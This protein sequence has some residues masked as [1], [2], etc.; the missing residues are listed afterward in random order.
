MA[1][2][3]AQTCVIKQIT[4][5]KVSKRKITYYLAFEKIIVFLHLICKEF[6]QE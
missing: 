5:Q 3:D 2:C 6:A 4:I 1:R